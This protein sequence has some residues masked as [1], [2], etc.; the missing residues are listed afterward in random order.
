MADK[1]IMPKKSK[2]QSGFRIVSQRYEIVPIDSIQPDPSNVNEG[3]VG[4]IHE[5]IEHN[6]FYG[7]CLVQASSRKILAGKHRWI[8]AQQQGAEELPV[9]VVD[10]DDDTATRIMLSDNRTARLGHDN[11]EQL[12]ELLAELANTEDGL[13]GTGFDADYLDELIGDLAG[14]GIAEDEDDY[15]DQAEQLQKKWKTKLDQVWQIGNHRV[16]CGDAHEILK[17]VRETEI[18]MVFTDPPYDMDSRVWFENVSQLAPE[19]CHMFVMWSDKRIALLAAENHE[20]FR[21][22]FAVDFRI[23]NL[24][25]NGMPMT[26]VDLVAEFLKGKGRMN[27]LKDGFTT[28]IECAKRHREDATENF[29]H[30]QAKNPELPKIFIEHYSKRGDVVLD[31]FLGSGSTLIAAEA[32]GR[33]CYGSEL[34]PKMLACC[35]ERAKAYGLECKRVTN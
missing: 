24:V 34:D 32:T 20:L 6:G 2:A 17:F 7:A 16:W 14:A 3:D 11:E 4:A 22:F 5:S 25:S 27:N 8:T 33:V 29:G 9:L 26:R 15:D 1:L 28:L 31:V 30:V 13:A 18:G 12:A 10:C 23:A 19:R 21:R 35:L